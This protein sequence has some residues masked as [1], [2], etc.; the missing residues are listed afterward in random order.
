MKRIL[1]SLVALLLTTLCCAQDLPQVTLRDLNGK[2]VPT[3]SFLKSGKP[4]IVS[5]FGT[6]CKPIIVSWMLFRKSMPIGR[7][8]RESRFMLSASTKGQMSRRF[9]P[10]STLITGTSSSSPT[11]TLT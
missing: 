5:F 3:T 9:V 8:R 11:P 2:P 6:W 7:T 10:L 4:I 1:L